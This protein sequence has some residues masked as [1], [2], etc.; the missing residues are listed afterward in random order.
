MFRLIYTL[1]GHQPHAAAAVAFTNT[2]DQFASAGADQQILVWNTNFAEPM[3]QTSEIFDSRKTSTKSKTKK[4][5]AQRT[6]S[7]DA[8]SINLDLENTGKFLS[9]SAF[10]IP[11]NPSTGCGD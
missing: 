7:V 10:I 8:K 2:G 5:L 4:K 1:H 6:T 11:A 3:D 9:K